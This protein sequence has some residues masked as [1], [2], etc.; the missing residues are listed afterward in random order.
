MEKRAKR[1][2]KYGVHKVS[3]NSKKKKDINKKQ[4]TNARKK[5]DMKKKPHLKNEA[6]VQ[7]QK[8][9]KKKFWERNKKKVIVLAVIILILLILIFTFFRIINMYRNNN[10]FA[11]NA[12]KIQNDIDN[13]IF[14]IEK[15]LIYSGANV[16]DLSESQ[17]LSDVNISQFTDFAIYISNTNSITELTEENTVN[18]LYIDNITVSETDFGT[19]KVYY[20][21]IDDICKYRKIETGANTINFIVLHTNEEKELNEESNVFYTDCTEP[22]VLSYVNENIVEDEDLSSN[23]DKMTLDGSILSYLDI[24]LEDLNYKISFT[25]NI[26]NNLGE[27][28]K[29]NCSFNIDL[30]SDEGG[31]YTGYIMQ[32]YDLSENNFEFIKVQ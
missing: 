24:D 10:I 30:D 15:I 17:N 13:P 9:D 31:I 11:Q 7:A 3:S 5:P 32:V 16:E 2:K 1:N 27:M 20:K 18:S 12:E 14:K 22:I 25:I 8:F 4:K 19:Q 28:Y 26:E 23:T 6:K 29:C 21:D